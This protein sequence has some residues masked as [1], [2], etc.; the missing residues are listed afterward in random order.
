[1]RRNTIDSYLE[2]QALSVRVQITF[3]IGHREEIN[4]TIR[5]W[6]NLRYKQLIENSERALGQM[7]EEFEGS[8]TKS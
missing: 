6:S 1:M 4:S 3:L 7:M 5:H 2:N 8:N